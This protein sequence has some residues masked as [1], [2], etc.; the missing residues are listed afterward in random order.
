[1][2]VHYH[3]ERS[4]MLDPDLKSFVEELAEFVED[5][6]QTAPVYSGRACQHC[7]GRTVECVPVRRVVGRRAE[8]WDPPGG[9][10]IAHTRRRFYCDPCEKV[11]S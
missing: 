1:M 2:I 4:V 5:N 3:Y 11:T 8:G 6:K 9:V 7:G 10:P